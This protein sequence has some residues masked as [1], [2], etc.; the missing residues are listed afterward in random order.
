MLVRK[1]TNQKLLGRNSF[2]GKFLQTSTSNLFDQDR[3]WESGWLS[4]WYW[5]WRLD[6]KINPAIKGPQCP[7]AA[8]VLPPH[9]PML[10]CNRCDRWWFRYHQEY[11]RDIFRSVSKMAHMVQDGCRGPH[12]DDLYPAQTTD[13]FV[14]MLRGFSG[15]WWGNALTTHVA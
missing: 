7:T 9:P 13:G 15:I 3:W 12:Q 8:M 6:K 11:A 5:S 2:R 1:A 4:G 10:S 14:R